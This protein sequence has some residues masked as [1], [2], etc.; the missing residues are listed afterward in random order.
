MLTL[1]GN[2]GYYLLQVLIRARLVLLGAVIVGIVVSLYVVRERPPS[3]LAIDLEAEAPFRD[4]RTGQ[5]VQWNRIWYAER[6][7]GSFELYDRAGDDPR[8]GDPLKHID[9]PEQRSRVAAWLDRL[10][11]EAEARERSRADSLRERARVDRLHLDSLQ[12][13]ATLAAPAQPALPTGSPRVDTPTPTQTHR[14]AIRDDVASREADAR[15]IEIDAVESL[16]SAMPGPLPQ[17]PES[18]L[19]EL[20]G[21]AV[22]IEFTAASRSAVATHLFRLRGA[23]I[24]VRLTP[25]VGRTLTEAP[26]IEYFQGDINAANALNAI[27]GD[28]SRFDMNSTRSAVPLR[29]VMP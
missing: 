22:H 10:R 8:T 17:F 15:A 6:G 14:A 27:L 26:L 12:V 16:A 19:R 18:W 4:T 7:G 25:L 13:Q 11:T 29:I 24:Q 1:L 28:V 2:L 20:D 5:A 21:R 23:G 3:P 9:S